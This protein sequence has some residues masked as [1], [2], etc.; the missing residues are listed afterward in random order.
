M[1][2]N[3]SV[4][5]N[6]L[7]AVSSAVDTRTLYHP[8]VW[9]PRHAHVPSVDQIATDGTAY[10]SGNESIVH[11][12]RALLS[13]HSGYANPYAQTSRRNVVRQGNSRPGLLGRTITPRARSPGERISRLWVVNRGGVSNTLALRTGQEFIRRQLH[14]AQGR[15]AVA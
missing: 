7:R 9:T 1:S 15:N 12:G 13:C 10:V 4:P 2:R 11:D 6:A 8:P 3:S 5:Q 14:L